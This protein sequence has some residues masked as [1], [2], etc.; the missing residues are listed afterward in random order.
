MKVLGRFGVRRR[1]VV[2]MAVLSV[3]ATGAGLSLSAGVAAASPTQV[4]PCDLSGHDICVLPGSAAYQ[5]SSGTTGAAAPLL[6]ALND[7]SAG[8]PGTS[9]WTTGDQIF[10]TVSFHGGTAGGA[11]GNDLAN[12]RFVEFAQSGSIIAEGQGC[13]SNVPAPTATVTAGTY[14]GDMSGDA[15]L[16]DTLDIKFTNTA[17]PGATVASHCALAIVN[18]ANG[19]A[20]SLSYTVGANAGTAPGSAG[21]VALF[22][23]YVPAA[24]VPAQT[25]ANW[26]TTNVT[27]PVQEPFSSIAS[28]ASVDNVSVNANSPAVSVLPHAIAAPISPVNI[29]ETVAAQLADTP[30]W[31]NASA[32]S[33]TTPGTRGRALRRSRWVAAPV[34]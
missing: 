2:G 27:V 1:L 4:L 24:A 23:D 13:D 7:S 3:V 9:I 26:Q 22:A 15:G 12:K 31:S 11:G 20:F 8:V 34:G 19:P 5:I 29:V 16:T 32:W 6:I 21:A 28:N 25:L 10:L 33:S 17:T 18:A 14:A 30:P